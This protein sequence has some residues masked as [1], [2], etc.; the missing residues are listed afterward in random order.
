[1]QLLRGWMYGV[2]ALYLV[3]AFV[4]S[5]PMMGLAL[6]GTA[7]ALDP[8]A[9]QVILDLSLFLGTIVAVLGI[10]LLKAAEEP[11]AHRELVRLVIWVELIAGFLLTAYLTIRGYGNPGILLPI[12]VAHAGI[13]FSGHHALRRFKRHLTVVKPIQ[14]VS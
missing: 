4:S 10:F 8:G 6:R 1:M 11:Q 13:A 2:G 5:P 12:A 7:V 3:L 9:L 14:R